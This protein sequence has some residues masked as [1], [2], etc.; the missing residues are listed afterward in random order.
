[1]KTS[2]LREMHEWSP[3]FSFLINSLVCFIIFCGLT[4][5]LLSPFFFSKNMYCLIKS[6]T[7]QLSRICCAPLTQTRCHFVPNRRQP[8]YSDDVMCQTLVGLSKHSDYTVTVHTSCVPQPLNFL[9]T[10]WSQSTF[11]EPYNCPPPCTRGFV[12]LSLSFLALPTSQLLC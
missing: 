11:G 3:F 9:F 7:G 5:P 6:S 1:M 2:C 12:T 10:S 8:F 4:L